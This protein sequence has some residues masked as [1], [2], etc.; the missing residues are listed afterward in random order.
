[1]TVAYWCVF[2]AAVL[3]YALAL[4]WRLGN[5]AYGLAANR[6]PRRCAEAL[7]GWRLRAHWAHL[8][9]FEAFAPFAAAVIV[10][11]QL[12]APQAR[13]DALA[14]AFVGFRLAHAGFYLADLGVPRSLAFGGGVACILA[15]FFAAV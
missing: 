4:S 12:G 11:H 9:G 2:T 13:I 3:P 6:I 7:T 8:N 15:I 5:P 10:A 14:L 1:M